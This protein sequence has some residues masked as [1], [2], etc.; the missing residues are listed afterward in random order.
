[1]FVPLEDEQSHV[2]DHD[3]SEQTNP[4]F[5]EIKYVEDSTKQSITEERSNI[6][7][8]PMRFRR[9]VLIIF[10]SLLIIGICIG[11]KYKAQIKGNPAI[12]DKPNTPLVE[13]IYSASSKIKS[14]APQSSL[15]MLCKIMSSRS[16]SSLCRSFAVVDVIDLVWAIAPL[17]SCR[18]GAADENLYNLHRNFIGYL[19]AYG[20]NSITIEAVKLNSNQT[21]KVARPNMEPY[22]MQSYYHNC[23][24]LR[25]N[26]LNMAIRKLELPWEYMI[27]VDAHQIFENPLWIFEA[28]VLAEKYAVVQLYKN[29]VRLDE[30]NQTQIIKRGFIFASFQEDFAAGMKIEFGNAMMIQ[31]NVYEKIGY[32]LDD[33]IADDCDVTYCRAVWPQYYWFLDKHY[34]RYSSGVFEWLYN[35]IPIFNGSRAYLNNNIIHFFHQTGTFP[36][37]NLHQILEWIEYDKYRDIKRDE[38]FAIY[39]ANQTIAKVVENTLLNVGRIYDTTHKQ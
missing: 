14:N 32:L 39:I 31:R 24:Y 22:E 30:R 38:N 27:W 1:M 19:N 3:Q 28:I 15:R 2:T 37:L 13:F 25:E 7:F 26:L 4:P 18:G 33:C 34:P 8:K 10:W 12:L 9:K 21:Y 29:V 17:Y 11:I 6:T 20:I 36:Y 35:T 23:S 16:S 5:K